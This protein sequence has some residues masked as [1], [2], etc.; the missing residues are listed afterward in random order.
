MGA[1]ALTSKPQRE[2]GACLALLGLPVLVLFLTKGID[3]L[4]TVT[5]AYFT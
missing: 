5:L 2:A 1:H 4:M 3:G